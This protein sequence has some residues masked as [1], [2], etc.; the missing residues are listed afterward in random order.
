[1][2]KKDGTTVWEKQILNEGQ[3]GDASGKC[4]TIDDNGIIYHVGLTG[5]DIFG[6]L[7]TGHGFYVVKLSLDHNLPAKK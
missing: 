2:L 1:M 5:S 3:S 4:V 6:N 7:K